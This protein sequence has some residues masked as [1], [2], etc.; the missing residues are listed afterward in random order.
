[1]EYLPL[2]VKIRGLIPQLMSN[3]ALVDALNPRV[4]QIGVLAKKRNRSDAEEL[5]MRELQFKGSLYLYDEEKSR[6][7]FW[8]GDNL[9][10]MIKTAAKTQKKGTTVE[11][12]LLCDDGRL[13]YDGPKDADGLWKDERF[14]HLKRT[15]RVV[16]ACR[17]QFRA[18]EVEF[19]IRYMEGT[20]E[21]RDIE[22]FLSYSGRYIGLSAWIRRYGLFEVVETRKEERDVDPAS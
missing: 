4:K 19:M 6:T 20:F 15:K 8:P 21:V 10:A 11:S 14:R 16:M 3:G 5:E 1:M 9:K 7:P 18:W 22:Q 13:I 12:A 2:Y 17:P